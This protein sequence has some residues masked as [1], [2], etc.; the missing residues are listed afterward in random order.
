[1]THADAGTLLHEMI[2]AAIRGESLPHDEDNPRNVY[3]TATDGRDQLTVK[4][5]AQLADAFFK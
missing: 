2:H 1:M 5:A 3:S 4:R